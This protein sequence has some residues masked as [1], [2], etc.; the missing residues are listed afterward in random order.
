[1]NQYVTRGWFPNG[2]GK[3]LIIGAN[4]YAVELLREIEQETP[5]R[6]D[7]F[8]TYKA[9]KQMDV[10]DNLPV[11]AFEEIKDTYPDA[12]VSVIIAIGYT[13]MNGIREKVYRDCLE[14]GFRICGY[15]SPRANIYSNEIG[16]GTIV[17]TGAHI[18]V[19]V[20]L[21]DGCIV[22]QG[23]T[24]THDITAGDFCFFGACSVFGGGT[25]IGSKCFFGLNCTIKNRLTI[26]DRTLVG[27][28]SLLLHDT[29]LESVYVGNPARKLDKK[30]SESHI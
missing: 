2:G 26:S 13:Q 29:E 10:L 14:Q 15:I 11:I 1:M 20:R 4:N 16:M 24:L 8:S 9:Y 17:R 27:A 19:N 18:G 25:T 23:V 3:I 12:Q 21:G 5:L 30:S 6:I 7:A 28:G 22:N